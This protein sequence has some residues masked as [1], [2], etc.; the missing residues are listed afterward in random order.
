MFFIDAYRGRI[1]NIHPSLLPKYSG[2]MDMDVHKLI[3]NSDD[4]FIGC[5]LHEVD[6]NIDK[7]RIVMQKQIKLS[8]NNSMYNP[9]LIKSIVQ[10]LEKDV[11]LDFIN[12]VRNKSFNITYKNSGVDIDKGNRFVEIIKKHLKTNTIGGFGGIFDINNTR[13]CASTDG[14]GTKLEL[15]KKLNKYDTGN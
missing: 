12:I 9:I 10:S 13:L 4:K 6:E 3:I 7:G 15:A 1:F 2:L 5:T 14:V 8:K 11:I